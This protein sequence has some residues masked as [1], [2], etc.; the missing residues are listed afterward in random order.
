LLISTPAFSE[1]PTATA[2]CRLKDWSGVEQTA[3]T[4]VRTVDGDTAHVKVDGAEYAVRFLT[5]DTPETHY[6]GMSQGTWGE[7]AAAHLKALL[8]VGAPVTLEFEDEPCDSYGRMLAHVWRGS[9]DI[10]WQ[11]VQDGMAVNYCIFPN[12]RHCEDYGDSAQINADHHLGIF[13]DPSLQIPYVWRREMSHRPEDRWVG[14]L[15]THEAFAPG[16]LD[17]VPVG[18]RIFFSKDEE[19]VPPSYEIIPNP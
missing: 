4:V 9:R 3:A 10:N 18:A 2:K 1:D 11:M 7:Q 6:N 15:K 16:N 8:P 13:S 14:N 12:V 19:A 5:I 17:S